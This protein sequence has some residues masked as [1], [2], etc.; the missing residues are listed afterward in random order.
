MMKALIRHEARVLGAIAAKDPIFYKEIQ[1]DK[2]VNMRESLH[3]GGKLADRIKL[4]ANMAALEQ[5]LIDQE[6]EKPSDLVKPETGTFA[7]AFLTDIDRLK[8]PEVVLD[9][10]IDDLQMT[11]IFLRQIA[12]EERGEVKGR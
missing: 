12:N 5:A 7:E 11:T 9:Y 3:T 2:Y 1:K 8:K 10:I 6:V 4:R